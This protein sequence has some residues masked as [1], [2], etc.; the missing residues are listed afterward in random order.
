MK[1]SQT[2]KVYMAQCI[3][4]AKKAPA[5]I[6]RPYVGALVLDKKENIIGKGY[7]SFVPGIAM[8]VHAERMALDSCNDKARGG[9]IVTTLEP[10]LHAAGNRVFKPCAHLIIERGI[11]RVI[12]GCHDDSPYVNHP[13]ASTRFLSNRGVEVIYAHEF[14]QQIYAELVQ[15]QWKSKLTSMGANQNGIA[16]RQSF[17]GL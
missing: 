8:L 15:G 14:Y 2:F 5:G 9:T 6:H 16:V 17:N 12:F 7:R 1:T 3:E 13:G 11:K 4:L 10:C